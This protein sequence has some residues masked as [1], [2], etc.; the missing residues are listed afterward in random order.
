MPAWLCCVQDNMVTMHDV[1]DA[2]YMYEHESNEAYLRYAV[3]PME[4]LLIKHKRI[5]VKDSAVNAICYGAKIMLPGVLR[6]D[7]DIVRD[8]EIVIVSTKGEAVCLGK[9][10]FV[11][12][13]VC[14]CVSMCMVLD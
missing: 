8:Q 5:I 4:R 14:V 6:Y 2:M 3:Q 11:L 12:R 7:D 10:V 1:L 9:F 13:F